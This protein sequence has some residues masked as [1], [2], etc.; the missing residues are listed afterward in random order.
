[1]KCRTIDPPSFLKEPMA[2][3]LQYDVWIVN[4]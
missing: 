3:L 2:Y 4:S 1:L